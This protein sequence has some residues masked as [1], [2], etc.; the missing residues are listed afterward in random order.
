MGGG[1]TVQAIMSLFAIHHEDMIGN[2]DP[3]TNCWEDRDRSVGLTG[4]SF[5]LH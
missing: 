1:H 3:Q 5:W 4:Q 2:Q